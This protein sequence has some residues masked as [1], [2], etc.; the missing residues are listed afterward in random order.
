VRL[1]RHIVKTIFWG[2]SQFLQQWYMDRCTIS[3]SREF[4]L[5]IGAV[6]SVTFPVLNL[7]LIQALFE[8]ERVC[9]KISRVDNP[10]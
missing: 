8:P 3:P 5:R 2:W 1:D 4:E 7:G 6:N 9:K 10:I